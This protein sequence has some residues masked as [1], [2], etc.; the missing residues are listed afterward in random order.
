MKTWQERLI[1]GPIQGLDTSEMQAELRDLLCL[2]VVGDQLRWM[3]AGDE[4]AELVDWLAEA[5]A[6]WRGW[7]DQVAKHLVS[8]GVPPVRALAKKGA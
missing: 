1:E 4:S 7:A 3:V 6:Q 2:A 8:L 5:T